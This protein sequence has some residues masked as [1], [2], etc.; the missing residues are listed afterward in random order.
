[1]QM[2][3]LYNKYLELKKSNNNKYYLFKSGIFFVFVAEDACAMSEELN[4]KITKLNDKVNKCGFP[5][6]AIDK[7]IEILNKKKIKFIIVDGITN[8]SNTEDYINRNKIAKFIDKLKTTD[9]DDISYKK[10]YEMLVEFRRI[11]IK[12]G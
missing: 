7:Y 10:A 2:S 6:S 8:I 12:N 9:L 5:I 1:M 11:A 3:K 4:L